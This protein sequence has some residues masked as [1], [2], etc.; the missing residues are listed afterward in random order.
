M[1]FP[2]RTAASRCSGWRKTGVAIITASTPLFASNSVSLAY[3]FASGPPAAFLVAS[4]F[5]GNKSAK[6]TSRAPGTFCTRLR[7]SAV[8]RPPHPISPTVTAEFCAL[9]RTAA[10]GTMVAADINCRREILFDSIYS[11]SLYGESQ[12]SFDN[13]GSGRRDTQPASEAKLH[14]QGHVAGLK[15]S[16]R[17]GAEVGVRIR[18]SRVVQRERRVGV[19]GVPVV[20][21][22]IRLGT[23]FQNPGFLSEPYILEQAKVEVLEPGP[24]KQGWRG[25][26]DAERCRRRQR[27]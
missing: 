1:C 14:R 10:N 2:A 12:W 17:D 25:I 6:A 19:A 23:E 26:P 7:A 27:E 4:I 5:S 21:D 22:V 11:V 8:P 20:Q 24:V 3:A 13:T 16:R 9:P 18:S 15:C